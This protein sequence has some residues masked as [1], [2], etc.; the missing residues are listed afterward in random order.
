MMATKPIAPPSVSSSDC[1]FSSPPPCSDETIPSSSMARM[2]SITAAP[3][4][5]RLSV[6]CSTPSSC[7]TRAVI[8][9][10]VATKAAATNS[11]LTH[12]K[13]EPWAH[14]PPAPN[15]MMTPRM[16]TITALLPT[17]FRSSRRVSRPT[18]N[19]SNTTPISASTSSGV[20]GMIC[21]GVSQPSS[22]GP[23][24]Q[25]AA[26]SPTTPGSFSR[27]AISAPI[28]AAMKMM[29]M[30]SRMSLAW[31]IVGVTPVGRGGAEAEA[32]QVPPNRCAF[33]HMCRAMLAT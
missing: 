18:E 16:P 31:C 5:T 33:I 6:R 17:F 20:P 11:E 10:E 29:K 25:P 3:R 13:P 27:W 12:S 14:N 1:T 28:C 24:T 26:I 22:D 4:M 8:P 7:S 19:S 32:N 15:G 21:S 30:V 2:S 9:A 23:T